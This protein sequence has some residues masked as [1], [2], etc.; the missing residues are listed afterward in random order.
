MSYLV[1]LSI[2]TLVFIALSL[3]FPPSGLGVAEPWD[4][5][6]TH[7]ETLS[8]GQ[9]ESAIVTEKEQHIAQIECLPATTAV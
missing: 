9:G 4:D 1:N 7:S 8:D 2:A 3:L 6:N 5:G